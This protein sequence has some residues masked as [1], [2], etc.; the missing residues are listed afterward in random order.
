MFELELMPVINKQE[1]KAMFP[2]NSDIF[3]GDDK[4]NT[5]S[6]KSMES[7]LKLWKLLFVKNAK[8]SKRFDC[9]NYSDSFMGWCKLTNPTMTV[10][11]IWVE[12]PQDG[13]ALNFF[14][15][16]TEEEGFVWSYI[17]PQTGEIIKIRDVMNWKPYYI[18]I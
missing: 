13:H 12:R 16:W 9:D 4:Y 15:H 17:E 18:R 6:L 10:G 2:L 11:T 1:I 8:Y 5:T 7:F 3:I 14:I